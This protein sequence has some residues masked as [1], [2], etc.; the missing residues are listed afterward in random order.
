MKLTVEQQVTVEE[1]HDLIYW[2][3]HMKHLDIDEW[4]GL[5]AIELCLTVVN[6]DPTKSALSTYFKLRADGVLYREYR[7]E[8]SQKRSRVDIPLI[9]NIHHYPYEESVRSLSVKEWMES[10]NNEILE[11]KLKGYTQE[12]I[13][14]ELGVSQSYISRILQKERKAYDDY[15][16]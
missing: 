1:N 3:I 2:Y 6:H 15:N 4:Y 10:G 9:E 11:Q 8:K 7:K 13:A 16:D 14:K 12:E 5:L